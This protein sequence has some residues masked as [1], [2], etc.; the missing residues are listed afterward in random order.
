MDDLFLWWRALATGKLISESSK[1]VMFAPTPSVTAFGWKVRP[2]E[3][4]LIADGSLPGFTSLMII[5]DSGRQV[6]IEL[7]NTREITHRVGDVYAAIAATLKGSTVAPPRRSLAEDV[8]I[9]VT[10][11]GIDSA[12]AQASQ[13][14]TS[15]RW[16][17]DESEFNRLG[18]FLLG[19]GRR[20]EAV[21]VLA[22]TARNHPDSWNAFDTLGEAY[23]AAGD[24]TEAVRNYRRSLELNPQNSNASA[25][26][27]RLPRQ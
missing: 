8:A 18:Y 9:A 20:A 5:A 17:E 19:R 25:I 2:T 1:A 6:V 3:G 7:T 26:L 23:L 22:W 27:A 24:T 16:Y 10:T 4:M 21:K 12:L 13:R 15:G 11:L 14:K